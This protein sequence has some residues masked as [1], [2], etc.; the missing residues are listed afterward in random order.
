MLLII[1]QSFGMNF[2]MSL[3]NQVEMTTQ[4]PAH[5]N[6]W[7][8]FILRFSVQILLRVFGAYYI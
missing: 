1:K 7:N 3:P 4:G 2:P 6:R 5:T 8:N